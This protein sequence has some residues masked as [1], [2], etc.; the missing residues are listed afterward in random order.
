MSPFRFNTDTVSLQGVDLN[1]RTY[2]GYNL[3]SSAFDI[4]IYAAYLY[5]IIK[6]SNTR[7]GT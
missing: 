3:I 4:S 5:Q 2:G 1:V 6:G 7:T